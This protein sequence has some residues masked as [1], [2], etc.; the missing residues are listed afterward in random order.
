MEVNWIYSDEAM[1]LIHDGAGVLPDGANLLVNYGEICF[2]RD[3]LK[4]MAAV[5]M[6]SPDR[7]HVAMGL[8]DKLE[9]HS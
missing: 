1:T 6:L 7:V 4:S 8:C 2:L 3:S 9:F 5:C